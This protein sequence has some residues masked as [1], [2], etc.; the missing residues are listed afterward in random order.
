MSLDYHENFVKG[1]NMYSLLPVNYRS[2][3]ILLSVISLTRSLS[4]SL[5]GLL[6][7]NS[8]SKRN[9]FGLPSTAKLQATEVRPG[10]VA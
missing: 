7:A 8:L 2:E 6:T 3:T 5:T 1:K 4:F 9:I 10:G